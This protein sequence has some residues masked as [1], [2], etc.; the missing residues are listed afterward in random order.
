[1]ALSFEQVL[2]ALDGQNLGI[3]EGGIS[4]DEENDFDRQLEMSD[5]D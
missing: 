1:M 4:T 3:D 2:K 5:S